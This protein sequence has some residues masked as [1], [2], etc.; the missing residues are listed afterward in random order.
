[1]PIIDMDRSRHWRGIGDAVGLAWLAEGMRETSTPLSFYAKRGSMQHTILSLLQQRVTDD[2]GDSEL[3]LI[4]DSYGPEI[5]DGA[6]KLRLEYLCDLMGFQLSYA[7]PEIQFASAELE[8][9]AKATS[10][11][12]DD[13][14]LL[15]PQTD[16]NARQ[17]PSC[18]WVD[19]AWEL[20]NRGVPVLV[21][22]G[23]EEKQY[24]N[25][26]RYLWGHDIKAVAALMQ[27]ARIVVGNDSG[28]AH[29]AGTMGTK[30]LAICGPTKAYCVFGHIPDVMAVSS[31]EPPGCAGCHFQ[32]PYRAACDLGCQALY[33]LKLDVILNLV[34]AHLQGEPA[35]V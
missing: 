11:L 18:Y 2:P 35:A 21:V 26:P 27:R 10:E 4:P 29:L 7:R 32:A 14:V 5:R 20:H 17:W 12:G 3:L 30:T 6:R 19:L 24:L 34:L 15:F 31:H 1:M 22:L 16:W 23:H 33:A 13:L 25:T 28:P 9:A 8:W